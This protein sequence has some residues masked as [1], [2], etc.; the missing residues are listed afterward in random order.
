MIVGSVTIDDA[1]VATGSGAAKRLYDKIAVVEQA[2]NPLPDPNN[3]DDDFDGTALDW[4]NDMLP[5]VVKVKRGWARQA[6]EHAEILAPRVI[7]RV[8]ADTTATADDDIISVGTRAGVVTVTITAGLPVGSELE[9]VD[10]S[11]QG[12]TFAVAFAASGGESLAGPSLTTNYAGRRLRKITSTL[13]LI[14]A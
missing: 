14:T 1:G 5:F 9:V 12:A 11:G 6:N 3:P 4:R 8:T 7:R 2:A 13:W 10:E